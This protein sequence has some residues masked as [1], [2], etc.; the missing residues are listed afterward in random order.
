[1]QSANWTRSRQCSKW[2]EE[3]SG[4]HPGGVFSSERPD[5]HGQC[6]SLQSS[7]NGHLTRV[8]TQQCKW[9]KSPWK[10]SFQENDDFDLM[11]ID[12]ARLSV[13]E[14]LGF[15]SKHC[16]KWTRTCWLKFWRILAAKSK[17]KFESKSNQDH[18]CLQFQAKNCH[19]N[20]LAKD[21]SWWFWIS[22]EP[23]ANQSHQ[24]PIFGS[25]CMN[26]NI[27]SIAFPKNDATML[28]NHGSLFKMTVLLVACNSDS[29][30]AETWKL[31]KKKKHKCDS[32]GNLLCVFQWEG[33]GGVSESSAS[34]ICTPDNTDGNCKACSWSKMAQCADNFMFLAEEKTL[35]QSSADGEWTR[36]SCKGPDQSGGTNCCKVAIRLECECKNGGQMHQDKKSVTGGV[37]DA[38]S[39][40]GEGGWANCDDDVSHASCSSCWEWSPDSSAPNAHN[41]FLEGIPQHNPGDSK[42]DADC[43]GDTSCLL[44][45]DGDWAHCDCNGNEW[46]DDCG[47]CTNPIAHGITCNLSCDH[48][49]TNAKSLVSPHHF[50]VTLNLCRRHWQHVGMRQ[51]WSLRFGW[52]LWRSRLGLQDVRMHWHK[53]SCLWEIHPTCTRSWLCSRMWKWFIK[54]LVN[55]Q[56]Q[57]TMGLVR[58]QGSSR[59]QGK[60]PWCRRRL[61]HWCTKKGHQKDAKEC[62]RWSTV[63]V[64]SC[65]LSNSWVM[66]HTIPAVS[67]ITR[68]MMM[69]GKNGEWSLFECQAEAS[70]LQAG[71]EC[72][73]PTRTVP[74]MIP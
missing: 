34:R 20:A 23:C 64:M 65:F 47:K 70:F 74:S 13:D 28:N 73:C 37:C 57:C 54:L 32:F 55:C 1:M 63:V 41:G 29:C 2:N 62:M 5:T 39:I 30:W 16:K 9:P 59:Q 53:W 35:I 49:C 45:A 43:P 68:M 6:K 18:F 60:D 19:T 27:A 4:Q 3:N 38:C 8:M 69:A 31:K 56:A 71:F 36:V 24:I 48:E 7:G 51:S 52:Q 42:H 14:T 21:K 12:S 72:H 67:L 11:T 25:T 61:L 26:T 10:T 50:N 22:I 66:W 46:M 58:R 40:T 15:R 17:S 33:G 44:N